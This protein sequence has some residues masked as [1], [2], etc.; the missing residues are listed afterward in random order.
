MDNTQRQQQ[1]HE[2][3]RAKA[4][5][6]INTLAQFGLTLQLLE[7]IPILTGTLITDDVNVVTFFKQAQ[8]LAHDE[9][10]GEFGK[11]GHKQGDSH[12]AIA[13]NSSYFGSASTL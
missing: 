2:P 5:I 3:A 10:F 8:K 6:Y 13:C 12:T 1:P 11:C 7:V 4:P 9:G